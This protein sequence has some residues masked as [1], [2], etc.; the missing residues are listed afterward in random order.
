M[1]IGHTDSS[2]RLLRSILEM[3]SQHLDALS[4]R[5]EEA[6]VLRSEALGEERINYLG[7]SYGTS[8]GQTY[9]QLFP[10]RL[11]AT[12]CRLRGLSNPTLTGP[13][14]VPVTCSP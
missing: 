7:F 13:I 6:I 14:A 5:R 8:I 1:T 9:A 3:P 12:G 10:S 4:V 11:R 2:E